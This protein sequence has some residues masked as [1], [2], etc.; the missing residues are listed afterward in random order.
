[1]L[2][3]IVAIG[4]S[5]N[6]VGEDHHLA[7]L[8]NWE[9]EMVRQLHDE[10]MTYRDIAEK[11]EVSESLVGKICRYQ[12]RAVTAVGFREVHLAKA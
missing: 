10:G 7:K 4:E 1:M 9:V 12:K 6:R 2:K 3:R 11:M 8:T 5:G